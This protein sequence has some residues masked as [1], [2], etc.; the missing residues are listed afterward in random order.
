MWQLI[1]VVLISL[2]GAPVGEPE[3]ITHPR[4]FDTQKV[5]QDFEK[6]DDHKVQLAAL[7][8]REM[9]E[10]APND[11]EIATLCIPAKVPGVDI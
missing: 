3:H 8:K 5:C 11:V 1:A 4:K 7:V 10:H 2:N 9:A 6:S